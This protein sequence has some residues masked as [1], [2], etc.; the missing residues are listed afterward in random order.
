MTK[1]VKIGNVV[2]SNKTI[3]APMSG[4]TDLSFRVLCRQYGAALAYVPLISSEGIIRNNVETK[5]LLKTDK[6]D[7]PLGV[8][9]FANDP[10]RASQ[11]AALAE[12]ISSPDFIDLNLGCPAQVIVRQ[13]CGSELL[14][15]PVLASNILKKTVASVSV[16]VT[17]KLRILPDMKKT[18]EIV[19]AIES[20]GVSAITVHGRTAK[21]M[22]SGVSNLEAVK[23]V[24][25][26]SSVPV[27][28]S[29]DVTDGRSAKH[30]LDKTLA[31]AVMIGRSALGNPYIFK[32]VNDYLESGKTHCF[33]GVQIREQ[34]IVDFLSYVGLTKKF[35]QENFLVTKAHA[36]T[37]AS[38]FSGSVE[39][40]KAITLIKTE[41]GLIEYFEKMK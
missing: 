5:G 4:Y 8:Q 1:P 36:L 18:L 34:K 31:D 6:K 14:K 25:E 3:L 35:S 27:F 19:S 40:R 11:A 33:T 22:Y 41:E 30:I 20:A 16:P 9:I 38:G 29:G 28:A 13:G 21:Q 24:K 12:K 32:N 2:I 37:F 15:D 39:M 26:A 23:Q 7:R 17:A 10:E